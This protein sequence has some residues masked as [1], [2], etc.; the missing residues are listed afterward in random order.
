MSS[1]HNMVGGFFSGRI[2]FV[3]SSLA[4]SKKRRALVFPFLSNVPEPNG[5]D[6]RH[7]QK[8]CRNAR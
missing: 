7:F 4:I 2:F 3:S 6:L 1:A 5:R 8:H